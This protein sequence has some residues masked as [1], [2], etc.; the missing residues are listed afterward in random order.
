MNLI[1]KAYFNTKEELLNKRFYL[2]NKEIIIPYEEY[3]KLDENEIY[4][5]KIR[6]NYFNFTK[7]EV[8]GND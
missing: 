1:T 4:D 7:E 6:G 2:F 8:K 3:E 5:L